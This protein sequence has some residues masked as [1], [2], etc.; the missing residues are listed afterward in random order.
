M[1][2]YTRG[3][4]EGK[5]SLFAGGRVSKNH[6]RL[7]ACGTVD[8][9]NSLLGV[10]LAMGAPE[11]LAESLQRVQNEL[12]VLGADLATPLEASGPHIVRVSAALTAALEGEIDT[13]DA[14]LP[15]LRHFILPGGGLCGAMLHLARTVCR[16]AER[17]AVALQD[18][19]EINTEVLRYLNRLSDWL[20]VAA[21]WANHNANISETLWKLK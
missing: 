20:F 7:H 10:A 18:S 4:D 11:T 8:E 14:N 6:A 21:R 9:L 1:K 5:T 17:W 3:G 19:E 13:W 12:F 2:I 15:P 16:R